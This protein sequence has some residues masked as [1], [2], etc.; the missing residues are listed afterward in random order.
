MGPI[1]TVAVQYSGFFGSASAA[2]IQR[3][4]DRL[5]NGTYEATGGIAAPVRL[6]L[7]T[8]GLNNGCVDIESQISYYPTMMVNNTYGIKVVPDEV[9][10]EARALADACYGPIA[11]CRAAAA[12]LDPEGTGAVA[13]VNALCVNVTETCFLGLTEIYLSSNV[14]VCVGGEKASRTAG[15]EKEGREGGN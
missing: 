9:Y 10:V 13:E 5:A 6:A 15:G 8:L 4:N 3:Q 12:E 11:E 2:Y 1:L 14:S 7:G